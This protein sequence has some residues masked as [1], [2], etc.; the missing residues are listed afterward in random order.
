MEFM[1]KK[2]FR[3]K[4]VLMVCSDLKL[5]RVIPSVYSSISDAVIC[6]CIYRKQNY[7]VFPF[8]NRKRKYTPKFLNAHGM[9]H[10]GTLL[11]ISSSLCGPYSRIF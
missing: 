9:V 3:M 10:Y 5:F 7:D 4:K 1:T 11:N 6:F 8:G 2:Y